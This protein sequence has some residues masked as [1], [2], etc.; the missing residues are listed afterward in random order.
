VKRSRRPCRPQ[1]LHP[2]FQHC[3]LRQ[4]IPRVVCQRQ[5]RE[6]HDCFQNHLRLADQDRR[7]TITTGTVGVHGAHQAV[8]N[9]PSPGIATGAS[10]FPRAH[11]ATMTPPAPDTTTNTNT[12]TTT[13]V[14]PGINQAIPTPSSST[15]QTP[16]SYYWSHDSVDNYTS[17]KLQK[18]AGRS[19][20]F[21]NLHQQD[22]RFQ[23]S[24]DT[25]TAVNRKEG[26]PSLPAIWRLS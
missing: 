3:P 24:P 25:A 26:Q 23:P 5:R 2:D 18:Q 12:N 15:D 14:I 1:W 16:R 13:A 9:L 19:S 11:L 6:N 17:M 21:S 10:V 20:R 8:V 22:G 7:L 4:C